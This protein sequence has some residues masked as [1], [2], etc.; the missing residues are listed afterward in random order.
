MRC[1]C[2]AEALTSV[3]AADVPEAAAGVWGAMSVEELGVLVYLNL[4][5]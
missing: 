1:A 2:S 4:S 3:P 5:W